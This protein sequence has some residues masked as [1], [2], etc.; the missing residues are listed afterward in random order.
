MWAEALIYLNILMVL[1][2]SLYGLHAIVISTL[3]L[4][5]R[6]DQMPPASE[7]AEWPVVAV[8]LPLYN[9]MYVAERIISSICAFNYPKEKLVIQVLD[10]STD[11]TTELVQELVKHYRREGYQIEHIRR[12]GRIGFKAGALAEALDQTDAEFLAVFDA[13]FVPPPDYLRCVIPYF[14]TDPR[15]GMVQARWGHLNRNSNI[16]TRTQALFLDGH[17]VIEQVA[18]T[19]SHLLSNFNGSG[20]VWKAECIR[21]SGG[22]AWD[23]LS[24]DI[25]LSFRAQLQ[26]W[27]LTFLPHIIVPAEVP[28]SL[29]IFKSQQYRWVFGY[30]QVFRKLFLKIWRAPHLTLPQRIGASFQLSTNLVNIAALIIFLLSLPLAILQPDQPSSLGLISMISSGPSILFALSQIFGYREPLLHR[31]SRLFYLPVLVILTVGLSISNT[32]AVLSALAGHQQEFNRTPKYNLEGR[33]NIWKNM[34]YGLSSEPTIWIELA[35]AF[36]CAVGLSFAIRG[37]P[38]LISL[39]ALGTISF[40]YVGTSSLITTRRPKKKAKVNVELSP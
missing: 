35:F 7:P 19:R 21:D 28:P 36:Y 10:D 5:H 12:E 33:K 40:G 4:I 34:Q 25:D 26:G 30:V 6:R 24:E 2:I 38:E 11:P 23:T 14:F 9:E 18:R 37:A 22:W 20:G 29:P 39:T 1:I 31:I 8:Q 16:L 13:D 17:Q 32:R 3:F 27:K 15:I